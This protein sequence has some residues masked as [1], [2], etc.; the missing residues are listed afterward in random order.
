MKVD[1]DHSASEKVYFFHC[2]SKKR[3]DTT[4]SLEVLFAVPQ[5]NT[6]RHNTI[7]IISCLIYYRC[8]SLIDQSAESESEFKK[9]ILRLESIVCYQFNEYQCSELNIFVM[10]WI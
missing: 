4:L 9:T 8:L 3:V 1:L 2:K 6:K 5:I 10:M 7:L